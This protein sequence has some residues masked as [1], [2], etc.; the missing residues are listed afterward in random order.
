MAEVV[1]ES[2]YE[3]AL[4]AL[5]AISETWAQQP[6]ITTPITVSV[7]PVEHQVT[8]KQIKSWVE[9]SAGSPK[10][11]ALRFRLKELLAR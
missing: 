1:A 9:K 4:T 6:G 2:L 5:K 11:A 3:A 7:V 10:E 8:L